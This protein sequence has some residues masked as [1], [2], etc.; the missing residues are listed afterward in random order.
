MVFHKIACNTWNNPCFK[1]LRHFRD[2]SVITYGRGNTEKKRFLSP[3]FYWP[4]ISKEMFFFPV[5]LWFLFYSQMKLHKTFH[6]T[7][8]WFNAILKCSGSVSWTLKPAVQS[9]CDKAWEPGW[10][11]SWPNVIRIRCV[12]EQVVSRIFYLSFQVS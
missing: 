11:S 1:F 5:F 8:T 12:M 3:I 6:V 9:K 2:R 10:F 4:N 7:L